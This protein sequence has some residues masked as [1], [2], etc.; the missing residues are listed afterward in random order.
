MK[1]SKF[2][3]YLDFNGRGDSFRTLEASNLDDAVVKVKETIKSGDGRVEV[4]PLGHTPGVPGLGM[5]D[6]LYVS[7][8]SIKFS[9]STYQGEVYFTDN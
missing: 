7:S 8:P 4:G 6:N 3:A 5:G 2:A 1:D 9:Y